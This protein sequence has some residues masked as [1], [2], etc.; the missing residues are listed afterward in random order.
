MEPVAEGASSWPLSSSSS[1]HESKLEVGFG[2][3][4]LRVLAHRKYRPPH[5][6]PHLIDH[7]FGARIT[8]IPL[9]ACL[10]Y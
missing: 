3:E 1:G 8:L 9:F 5:S 10:F 6:R 2:K 7:I 4:V